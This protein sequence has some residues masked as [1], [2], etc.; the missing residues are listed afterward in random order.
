MH[1]LERH[2]DGGTIMNDANDGSAYLSAVAGLDPLFEHIVEPRLVR[3]LRADPATAVE[4]LQLPG[5]D[6][7]VRAAIEDLDIRYVFLGTGFIRPQFTRLPG[8]TGVG[9]SP[10]LE[11]IHEVRGVEIYEVDV[12][13][14][15][16][17]PVPACDRTGAT[18]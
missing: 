3:S 11:L 15:P 1:W 10:S 7:D 4:A 8:L 18:G 17:E 6:P 14:A 5:P 2:S 9:R 16:T 12:S 13:G